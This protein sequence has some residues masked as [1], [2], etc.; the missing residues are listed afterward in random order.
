MYYPCVGNIP[1]E[2]CLYVC[3]VD[4]IPGIVIVNG[5]HIVEIRQWQKHIGPVWQVEGNTSNT[6]TT[7][8]QNVLIWH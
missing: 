5:N 3:V 7:R 1:D 4:P 2:I 8:K 6:A